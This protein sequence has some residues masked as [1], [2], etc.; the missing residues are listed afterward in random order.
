MQAHRTDGDGWTL[1]NIPLQDV[2]LARVRDR[3]DLFYL[4]AA[5][6]FIEIAAELYTANLV[7]T[8]ADDAEVRGWLEAHWQVEEVRHGRALRAYVNHVW[9][10]F[11]WPRAYAAF[12]AD[13]SQHCTVEEFEPTHGLEMVARCVV[14]TGTSTYYQALA[15]QTDEPVL[16]G[17]AARIRA[18]EIGHY[19]HFYRYFRKFSARQP[20]GRLAVLGALRR[21]LV[22]AR[23]DDAECA[24]RHVFA[25]RDGS[26]DPARLH[27]LRARLVRQMKQQ[28]PVTMAARMLLKPLDLPSGVARV[29]EGPV[30]RWTAWVLQR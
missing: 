18:E 9:P 6:S 2:D 27:A 23:Q 7:Q 3:E 17:I 5:A 19:K 25:V 4:V 16:A 29:V 28:Y 1:D 10:D 13:Y 22:E 30:A 12:Y 11:D 21:R 15:A 24:L 8:F 14:E 20:T 26:A